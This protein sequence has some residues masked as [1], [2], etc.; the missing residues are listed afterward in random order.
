MPISEKRTRYPQPRPGSIMGDLLRPRQYS[1]CDLARPSRNH[2]QATVTATGAG[3]GG[4]GVGVGSGVGVGRRLRGRGRASGPGSGRVSVTGSTRASAVG[5][6]VGRSSGWVA[7]SLSAQAVGVAGQGSRPPVARAW[8]A[9]RR[10]SPASGRAHR[11]RRQPRPW[12]PPWPSASPHRRSVPASRPRDRTTNTLPLGPRLAALRPHRDGEADDGKDEERDAGVADEVAREV[13]RP[14][15]ATTAVVGPRVRRSSSGP[16]LAALPCDRRAG[17]RGHARAGPA[18][19]RARGTDPLRDLVGGEHHAAPPPSASPSD[20]RPV[21]LAGR[22]SRSTIDDVE[23]AVHRTR[24]PVLGGAGQLV[25]PVGL[26]GLAIAVRE[27]RCHGSPSARGAPS[28]RVGM[29]ALDGRLAQR[30][31]RPRRPRDLAFAVLVCLGLELVRTIEVA[32]R[33]QEQDEPERDEH[34]Q[35]RVQLGDAR[36]SS[37]RTARRE[38]DAVDHQDGL[39]VRQAEVEQPVVDVRPVRAERRAALARSAGR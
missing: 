25:R 1:R 28:R 19:R 4:V 32:A 20:D 31:G 33:R 30:T 23:R 16:T 11:S 35:E 22:T 13:Q 18:R 38:A 15:A 9:E 17:S 21:S 24:W 14:R 5:V 26:A 10:S 27:V 2:P 36:Q 7:V 34:A 12:P 3:L 29:L 8:P 37:D 6:G 39:A